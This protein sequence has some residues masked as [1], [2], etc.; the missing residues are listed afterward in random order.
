MKRIVLCYLAALLTLAALDAAWF[1][2]IALPFH[3]RALGPLLAEPSNLAAAGLFY[4]LY[5]V[6]V[7][8]FA[9]R[10]G[11]R[12]SLPGA[13]G[14]G[15]SFGFMAYMTLNLSNLATLKDW[16]V[17]LSVVDVVWGSLA[18]AVAATV[19]RVAADRVR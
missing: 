18:T 16:P 14:W 10:P 3:E 15:A 19:A 6:G 13:A 8:A 4:L 2:G 1:G 9:A 7:L 12:G 11:A 5:A 17:G